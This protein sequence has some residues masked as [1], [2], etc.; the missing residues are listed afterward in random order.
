M[1]SKVIRIKKIILIFDSFMSRDFV[2][3]KGDGG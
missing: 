3:I 1:T 2:A